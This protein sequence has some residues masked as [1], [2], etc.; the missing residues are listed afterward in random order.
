MWKQSYEL[1]P[2]RYT[3]TPLREVSEAQSKNY[4]EVTWLKS[5]VACDDGLHFLPLGITVE[6]R[7]T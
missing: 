2:T 5:V 6:W 7:I 3:N 4:L 1:P